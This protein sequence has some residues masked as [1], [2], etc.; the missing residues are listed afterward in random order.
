[1]FLTSGHWQSI[2]VAFDAGNLS[3]VAKEILKKTDPKNVIICGDDDGWKTQFGKNNKGAESACKAARENNIRF[4]LPKFKE[5]DLNKTTDFNDLHRVEGLEA[6]KK[7][8]LAVPAAY[9][10]ISLSE[11]SDIDIVDRPVISGL[12]GEKESLIISAASGVGK[13]LIANQIAMVAGN[14]P[15]GGLWGLFKIPEIVTS[16]IVQSENSMGAINRRLRKKFKANPALREGAR[17][18]FMLKINGDV[19]LSGILTEASFQSLL[20][21]RLNELEARLLI[22]DPLV[23]YHDKDENDNAAMRSVLD[24]VTVVCDKTGVSA[25]ICH[26]FNRQNIT[27]GAASI[28]DWAANFLLLNFEE[29]KEGSTILR[30]VHDKSRNYETVPDFFLERTPDLQ[31]LRCEKPGSK[32]SQQV[33]SVVT[34]LM[35]MGGYVD[36]QT[37]LKNAL[38]VELNCGEATARRAI[39]EALKMKKIIITPGNKRGEPNAYSLPDEVSL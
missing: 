18:V 1:M 8:I 3:N 38:M 30:C 27:R 9:E 19:R 26:H 33:N 36:S 15:E 37:P 7:Q 39:N 29:K 22:L 5:L 12:L 17:N 20:V 23:S 32:Q 13:S 28:R 25:I 34:V 6:V 11:I 31:F 24:A 21:D 16:L 4:I 35:T 2:V 10:Y 14:P